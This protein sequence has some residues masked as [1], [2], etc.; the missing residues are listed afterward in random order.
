MRRLAL[1]IPLL[2][3]G[4]I[5]L[6]V[7]PGHQAQAA[8]PLQIDTGASAQIPE[9]GL[10]PDFDIYGTPCEEACRTRALRMVRQCVAD[11]GTREECVAKGREAYHD[12]LTRCERP[13]C[14]ET[15]RARVQRVYDA[16]IASGG[17]PERCSARSRTLYQECLTNCKRTRCEESCKTR[18]Q[19]AVRQCI[20]DGGTPERCELRG[21]TMYNQCVQQCPKPSLGTTP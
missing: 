6:G 7:A 9:L 12:C 5:L 11:G 16:C 4:G 14:D 20:A 18:A 2:F 17:T 10:L 1:L 13:T 15:C 21:R 19:Q 3:V 8:M